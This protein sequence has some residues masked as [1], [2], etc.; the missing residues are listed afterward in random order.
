MFP[1]IWWKK[2]GKKIINITEDKSEYWST[3]I[4]IG[5]KTAII[6]PTTGIKLSKK[7]ID[8]FRETFIKG[9]LENFDTKEYGVGNK[10]KGILPETFNYLL[11]NTKGKETN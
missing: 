9:I 7:T 3:A 10:E 2:A 4:G 6:D 11:K 1:M 8:N 5:S